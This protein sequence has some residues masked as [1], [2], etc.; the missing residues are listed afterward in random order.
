MLTVINEFIEEIYKKIEKLQNQALPS[1]D[2]D[3]WISFL[4]ETLRNT[5]ES[6]KNNGPMSS[7]Y[8]S[9]CREAFNFCKKFN[10]PKEFRRLYDLITAHLKL[11]IQRSSTPSEQAY[12]E[13]YRVY[14]N[15]STAEEHLETRFE[16]LDIALDLKCYEVSF[17]V[18]QDIHNIMDEM[19][20]K[21][22]KEDSRFKQNNITLQILK[23]SLI[24]RYYEKLSQIFWVSK[25]YLYHAFSRLKYFSLHKSHSKKFNEKKEEV[26]SIVLLSAICIPLINR[27]DGN[28]YQ[29][30]SLLNLKET[31]PT[32]ES[33]FKEITSIKIHKDAIAE[34]RELYELLEVELHPLTLVKQS[35]KAL[36]IIKNN[37]TYS[38]Y[39]TPIKIVILQKI[40]NQLSTIYTTMKIDHF[41]KLVKD[42]NLS[43]FTVERIIIASIKSDHIHVRIDHKNGCLLFN[44]SDSLESNDM[45]TQLQVLCN[46]LET[47]VNHF[48]NNNDNNNT[49][50]IDISEIRKNLEKEYKEAIDRKNLIEKR[51]QE[52]ENNEMERRRK[53]EEKMKKE[54]EER[55]EKERLRMIEEQRKREIEKKEKMEKEA[56]LKQAQTA[57][58]RL[59]KVGPYSANDLDDEKYRKLIEESEEKDRKLMIEIVCYY[60]I[61]K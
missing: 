16:L 25:N 8:H 12:T 51:K 14:W 41:F 24:S 21:L 30:S 34:F 55:L 60:F 5:L 20:Q 17:M 7:L 36:E 26:S 46:R 23:P 6:L 61:I 29:Y 54:E 49:S 52:A 22:I 35:L 15:F 59:G 11:I 3:S 45:K 10:R 31:I 39:E 28:D 33:L 32:R 42:L 2:I 43:E 56:K 38:Q 47:V 58:K 40:L 44:N 57:A 27:N 1:N 50:N 4:Y 48:N 13:K 37:E 53:L 9:F 18:I 19:D